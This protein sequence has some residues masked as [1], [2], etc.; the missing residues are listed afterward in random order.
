MELE[1]NKKYS[2]DVKDLCCTAKGL[3]YLLV[4][5]PDDK[6]YKVF[7]IIKGQY[8]EVP[9]KVDCIVTGLD[10]YGNFKIKQDE[11]SWLQQE[12]EIGKYRLFRIS[13]RKTDVNGKNYY[14]IEDDYSFQRWYSNDEFSIGDEIYL[15]AKE[16]TN[17]GYIYYVQHKDMYQE[18]LAVSKQRELQQENVDIPNGSVFV[19]VEESSTIEYKSSIV[20]TPKGE[21]N[22]DEQMYNIV[23]ELASFMNAEGGTLYIGVNDKTKQ[24]VGI[25]AD[26][27]HL[28]EGNSR[29]ADSYTAD[30]DHYQLKIRDSLVSLCSAAAGSLITISFPSQ[31]GIMYCR[32][33]VA[34]AK[35]PVWVK[36]NVL[37]QRQGNQSRILK[38]DSLTQ[39][40]GERIG[41]YIAEM[42]GKSAGPMSTCDISSMISAAVK[43]AI[44]D[45]YRSIAAPVIVQDSEPKYWVVWYNDATWSRQRNK[46]N[47]TNVFKQLPVTS[48]DRDVVVAFCYKKGLVNTVKLSEFKKR[49]K[50]GEIND[51]GYNPNDV[52]MDI[53][54]C[55]PSCLLAVHSVDQGGIEY[56][57]LHHLTDFNTTQRATNQGSCIIPKEKGQVLGYR[58]VSPE[59]MGAVRNLIFSKNDTSQKF[60]YNWNDITIQSDLEALKAL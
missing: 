60:G 24:L 10:T 31:D 30:I 20:F 17:S 6:L 45:R 57:K 15:Y 13:D 26:L 49:T 12:Y 40:V 4:S 39:F 55:H 47:A 54:I 59:Q 8:V 48:E 41:V 32:V 14:V 37:Y 42:A 21:A 23:S 18:L 1:L 7:N 51:R 36:G 58:T 38:G 25:E 28:N 44:N 27:P 35:Q 43:S 19:G 22:I 33:D 11:C 56:I 50:L 52:P 9:D 53:F 46:Q 29:Y 3:D 5:G 16:V 34:K 2:F